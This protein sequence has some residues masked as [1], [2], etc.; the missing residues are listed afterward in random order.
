[1]TSVIQSLVKEKVYENLTEGSKIS[2][3]NPIDLSTQIS[4]GQGPYT[5]TIAEGAGTITNGVFTPAPQGGT[6]IIEVTD[7]TGAI[8]HIRYDIAKRL[9]ANPQQL[10]LAVGNEFTYTGTFG[11][12]PYTYT[13]TGGTIDASGKFTADNSATAATITVTDSL[14]NVAVVN[15]TVQPALDSTS[16]AST[17]TSANGTTISGQDGVPPYSYSIVSGPGSINASTGV[18]T[19]STSGTT[20]IRI[21]DSLGNTSSETITI[22]SPLAISPTTFLTLANGTTTFTS[23]GGV[24]PFTYSVGSGSTGSVALTTG[25]YTASATAPAAD[26]VIVT[27][28][29]GNTAS[30]SIT[31]N[32]PVG[33]I[34]SK[35]FLIPSQ[36]NTITGVNGLPPYS[37]SISGSTATIN[38]S[39]GV[40]TS[41]TTFPATST[42]TVQDSTGATATVTISTRR[43]PTIASGLHVVQSDTLSLLL[44]GGITPNTYSVVSGGGSVSG[45]TFTAPPT[46]GTVVIRMTDN[47][48]NYVDGTI[49]VHGPPTLSAFDIPATRFVTLTPDLTFTATNYHQWCL[50]EGKMPSSS[51]SW[52]TTA[53]P[54]T[55]SLGDSSSTFKVNRTLSAHVQSG[56]HKIS[57]VLNKK[58]VS[59]FPISSALG[60]N[61]PVGVATDSLGNIY[62]SD[63]DRKQVLKFN[64]NGEWLSSIGIPGGLTACLGCL[65]APSGIAIDS[66]DNIYVASGGNDSVQKFSSDGTPILS[67]TGGSLTLLHPISVALD[68]QENIYIADMLNHRIVKLD[69]DGNNLSTIGS[70]GDGNG[71]FRTIRDIALDGSGNLY[72]VDSTRNCVQKFNTS[73]AW[74]MT[75]NSSGTADGTLANPDSVKLDASGN[76]YVTSSDTHK[77]EKFDSSGTWLA[78]YGGLG[79]KPGQLNAPNK[80]TLLADGSM[81]VVDNQNKRVQKLNSSGTVQS[82]FGTSSQVVGELS[83]PRQLTGDASGNLYVVDSGNYRI[84]KFNSSGQNVLTFGSRGT[85]NGQFTEPTGIAVSTD[86]SIYVADSSNNNLQKFSATGQWVATIATAGSGNGQLAA[87]KGLAITVAQDILVVDSGNNRVQKIAADG[88]FISSLGTLGTGNGQFTAPTAVAVDSAGNIWVSELTR[89]QKFNSSG[90]YILSIL[91]SGSGGDHFTGVTG[92][93]TDTNDDIFLADSLGNSKVIH[94]TAAGSIVLAYFGTSGTIIGRTSKLEAVWKDAAGNFFISDTNNHRI[95]KFNSSRAWLLE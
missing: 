91:P 20:V 76:I 27:D 35:T 52:N 54:T 68:A 28:S 25:V 30:A 69:K 43:A 48:G 32:P 51:C 7:S 59:N 29:L 1:M 6:V 46:T 92:L 55:Y 2:V 81:L 72:A 21:T 57:A 44:N 83:Y 18:Y 79:E 74:V 40:M 10:D 80:M 78:S 13:A 77:I 34:A 19:S 58:F 16:S 11:V 71:Q 42:V 89:V 93:F 15:V 62:V 31:V 22:V 56:S 24:A 9:E 60:L 70:V 73:G 85:G 95:Q 14:N 38:S 94:Y 84:Q 87:P 39:T 3:D 66:H 49:T 65:N 86:G 67:I 90:V 5:Y 12:P 88:T 37:Y 63:H 64:Q 61:Y 8:Q 75:I 53:I 50:F 33:V 23:S 17:I 36:T 45:G 26:T 82:Y 47:A 4:S 41:G